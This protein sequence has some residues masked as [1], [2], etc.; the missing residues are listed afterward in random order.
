MIR[1]IFTASTSRKKRKLEIKPYQIN[2]GGNAELNKM[3]KN[4]FK[5]VGQLSYYKKHDYNSIR[6]QSNSIEKKANRIKH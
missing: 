5:C 3:S 4:N 1:S 6:A 2:N